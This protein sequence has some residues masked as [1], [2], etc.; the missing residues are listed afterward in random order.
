MLPRV[1]LFIKERQYL[2]GVTAATVEGYTYSLCYLPAEYPTQAE[3]QGMIVKLRERGLKETTVNTVIRW[4]NAYLHW[5]SGSDQKCNAGCTHPRLG[6][7]REPKNVLPT[8]TAAQIKKLIQSK[9]H[10]L[11][12]KKLHLLVLFLLDTGS[13]ISEALHVL[14]S[15]IDL[16]N[17]LVTLDGK[18][19]K[20]RIVPFSVELR[21]AMYKFIQE[22]QLDAYARLFGS[23]RDAVWDRR[24][25]L[26]DVKRLCRDLG[27]EPPARTLHSFRHTFAMN[28]LR[29]GGSTFHLQ[30]SLGHSTLEMTR[31]Y[32]NLNTEDL[33]A[34]HPRI[35]LLKPDWR[36]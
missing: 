5:N 17:L 3:L 34:V 26:R 1:Q 31:R 11:H 18:G 27:F 21:K 2:A 16:D 13:R 35:S 7:L 30:R 32:A 36:R 4:T 25:A 10:T 12:Q 22:G 23:D 14:I 9:P 19:R 20:Q 6:M 29:R 33:Q 24:N 15:D 8:F 28:Y